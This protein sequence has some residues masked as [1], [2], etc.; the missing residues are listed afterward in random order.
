MTGR[1]FVELN[2]SV[3]LCTYHSRLYLVR[4]GSGFQVWTL[5]GAMRCKRCKK[6]TVRDVRSEEVQVVVERSDRRRY[7]EAH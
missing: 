4:Q 3:E 1:T 5:S 6:A 2:V 7:A